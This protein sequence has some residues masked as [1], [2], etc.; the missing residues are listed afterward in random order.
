MRHGN[1]LSYLSVCRGFRVIS[2]PK[3]A[4][5]YYLNDTIQVAQ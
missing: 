4:S 3:S 1:L 2:H 5:L